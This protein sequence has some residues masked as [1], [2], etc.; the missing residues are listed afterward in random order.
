[1]VLRAISLETDRRHVLLFSR[2]TYR[3]VVRQAELFGAIGASACVM[4]RRFLILG[5][6]SVEQKGRF[7][8][9]CLAIGGSGRGERYYGAVGEAGALAEGR[10][11]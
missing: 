10:R 9:G 2:G 8:G 3:E 5:V 6:G 1:M 11:R 4:R 7:V